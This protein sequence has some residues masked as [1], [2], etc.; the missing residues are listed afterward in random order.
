M[1]T[2]WKKKLH[3]ILSVR[4][5]FHMTDSLSI[6]VHIFASCVL[7]SFLVDEMLLPRWV[8]LSTSF[9]GPPFSVEMLPLWLKHIYIYIYICMYVC[10]YVYTQ[11]TS[12]K[13]EAP[14]HLKK[15]FKLIYF[16]IFLS[17]KKIQCI[18]FYFFS[19]CACIHF[20]LITKM[21]KFG[22][23]CP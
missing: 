22:L 18:Y 10:M 2:A 11:I 17:K 16:C 9:R 23:I 4:S 21:A 15:H 3:F 6:A 12:K 8:N 1:T 19:F 5:D 13:F 7:M 20:H 14:Q